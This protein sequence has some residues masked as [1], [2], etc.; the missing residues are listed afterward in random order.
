MSTLSSAA[1]G[2]STATFKD[3]YHAPIENR[4][5][6]PVVVHGHGVTNDANEAAGQFGVPS[7]LPILRAIADGGYVV[8]SPTMA[9][10][11]G[12]ATSKSRQT[13]VVTWAKA[14]VNGSNAKIGMIGFSHGAGSVL[15]QAAD[16]GSANVAWVIGII[17]AVDYTAIRV[18]NP[19]PPGGNL[20]A[21]IDAAFSVT[22]PAA[23]P[24]GADPATR[25]AALAGIPVQMWTSSDDL[26][27]QN[28]QAFCTT[29]GGDFHNLGALGHTDAAIAAVDIP[30]VLSFI[31]AHS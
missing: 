15:N 8:A 21:S 23:L 12:N 17:P 2:R 6:Y 25:T 5:S 29:L 18:S 20:R 7:V 31:A 9:S 16:L 11:W 22:Y 27:S 1:T 13:D 24:A 19:T 3:Y 4:R 10:L 28:V 14:S 30:T 26:V